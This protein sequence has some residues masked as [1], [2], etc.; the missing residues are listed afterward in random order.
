MH[1]LHTG[2]DGLFSG[3]IDMGVGSGGH[4]MLKELNGYHSYVGRVQKEI[5]LKRAPSTKREKS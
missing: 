5:A 3:D 1:H 4:V 2:L